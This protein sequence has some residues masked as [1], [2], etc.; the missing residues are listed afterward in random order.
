M[1]RYSPLSSDAVSSQLQPVSGLRCARHRA[2][3]GLAGFGGFD[4]LSWL[5][6]QVRIL[7]HWREELARSPDID[8]DAVVSVERHYQWLTEEVAR[9]EG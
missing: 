1:S 4:M 8:L 5:R 3:T 7:E 9:L 6:S 2:E